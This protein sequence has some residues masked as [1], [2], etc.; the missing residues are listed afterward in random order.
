MRIN[1][2]HC[3]GCDQ[4]IRPPYLIFKVMQAH[5]NGDSIH[6]W[7]EVDVCGPCGERLTVGAL[8]KLVREEEAPNPP[9]M[10]DA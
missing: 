5:G 8:F 6:E 10:S 9:A 4:P 1:F 2:G 7:E 3:I